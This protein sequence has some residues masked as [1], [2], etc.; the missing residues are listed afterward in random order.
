MSAFASISSR[1]AWE[2]YI[3]QIRAFNIF[4]VV[5]LHIMLMYLLFVPLNIKR[6]YIDARTKIHGVNM[7]VPSIVSRP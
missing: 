7:S 1:F 2:H 3:F 6:Q 4:K 5:I